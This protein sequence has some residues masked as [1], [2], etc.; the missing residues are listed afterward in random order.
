[1]KRVHR[2]LDDLSCQCRPQMILDVKV[3]AFLRD[4]NILYRRLPTP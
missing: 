3:R 2:G 1:M 4:A